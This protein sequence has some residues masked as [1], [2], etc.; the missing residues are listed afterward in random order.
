MPDKIRSESNKNP[1]FG[2]EMKDDN[3]NLSIPN[4]EE[5]KK[6][7]SKNQS[8]RSRRISK[9]IKARRNSA[10]TM[11]GLVSLDVTSK[12]SKETKKVEDTT[13]T[14]ESFEA[15]QE[16]GF[17][18][19]PET[20]A[21]PAATNARNQ[22]GD[23][24]KKQARNLCLI[25]F[26][27]LLIGALI[28]NDQGGIHQDARIVFIV[29]FTVLMWFFKPFKVPVAYT[30]LLC[31]VLLNFTGAITDFSVIM[32]GASTSSV[33]VIACGSVMSQSLENDV[34]SNMMLRIILRFGSTRMRFIAVLHFL[35]LMSSVFIPSGTLKFI[36]WNSVMK[37]I[38]QKFEHGKGTQESA[39][40]YFSLGM[41]AN[42]ASGGILTG[43]ATNLIAVQ[44]YE[45]VT[46]KV[47]SYVTYFA[48]LGPV[49]TILPNFISFGISTCL[50]RK[51]FPNYSAKRARIMQQQ[52]SS[53]K[54]EDH[55][56]LQPSESEKRQEYK[57]YAIFCL[58]S[59]GWIT[60]HWTGLSNGAIGIFGVLLMTFPNNIGPLPW[61]KAQAQSW[62]LIIIFSG[63][64]VFGSAVHE[65]TL[66]KNDMVW[67]FKTLLGLA[68]TAFARY[69]LIAVSTVP[70]RLF[71]SAAA[72]SSL[73][74]L[75]IVA[76]VEL[77]L[78]QELCFYCI[79][80]SN[81]AIFLPHQ[82]T[83]FLVSQTWGY[84]SMRQFLT[85]MLINLFFTVFVLFPLGI[86][87]WQEVYGLLPPPLNTT[88]ATVAG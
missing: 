25:L 18:V 88:N 37:G 65:S 33:W 55:R 31:F 34:T 5:K 46:G 27:P 68:D 49:F 78:K 24:F 44:V 80:M 45:S 32:H 57:K 53:T 2:I 40:L 82:Q 13:P 54:D 21:P 39:L 83:G 67:L 61:P 29:L 70:M 51:A 64:I 35:A 16:W 22:D 63:L 47:V 42:M 9:V 19:G 74:P 4:E 30:T 20:Q 14:D 72:A 62:K 7:Q 15:A 26:V 84:F 28:C 86:F 23:D 17:C 77:G 1:A 10:E 85:W 3:S 59:L 43:T 48:Y 6:N 66:L 12:S 73:T 50:F 36:L 75:V 76:G 11:L 56:S 71:G 87:Y 60:S 38:L 8:K 79:C 52:L 81:L 69:W 41:A 58:V